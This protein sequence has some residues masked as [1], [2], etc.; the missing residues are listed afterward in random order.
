MADGDEAK[1]PRLA[2]DGVDDLKAADAIGTQVIEFT[3][4]RLPTLL[5][6]CNATNSR[7]DGPLQVWMERADHC[8]HMWRD[9]RLE[10]THAVRRFLAGV[11]GSPNT[12]SSKEEPFFPAL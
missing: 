11:N 8:S 1:D 3:Y 7:F 10:R 9:I 6:D 5:R 12:S 2:V 4:G